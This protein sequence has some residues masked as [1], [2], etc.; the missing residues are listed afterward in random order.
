MQQRFAVVERGYVPILRYV[1]QAPVG[2]V[3]L[4]WGGRGGGVGYL[5]TPMLNTTAFYEG[6][7][8]CGISERCRL[9]LD[10]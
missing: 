4:S 3:S 10:P 7:K 5:A 9:S 8:F 6:D 2:T 1:S